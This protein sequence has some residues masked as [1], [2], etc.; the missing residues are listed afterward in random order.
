MRANP[1]AP[2]I[3][4][5]RLFDTCVTFGRVVRKGTPVSVTADNILALMDKHD[6]AEALV[7]H[8]EAR[9]NTPRELGNRR[10]LREIDGLP[11]VHPV[12][13]LTPPQPPDAG[14]ARAVVDEMLGSGVKAAR[15][16]MS[17]APP[18]PWLWRDLLEALEARRVPCLLDFGVGGFRGSAGSTMGAPDAFD[19]HHLRETALAHPELPMI[20]SHVCCGVGLPQAVFSLF[21]EC[22]NVHL[23]VLGIITY[24]RDVATGLGPE[25]VFFASGMPFGDPATYVSNV[26]YARR[27]TPEDKKRICGDNMRRL[28]GDVR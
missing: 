17:V 1:Q 15:L 9:L 10:L 7:H 27:L 18:L 11:R 2:P 12:W 6:I 26:Q 4:E 28:L 24:W 19:A 20:L 8:N 25:R 22:P 23:D 3:D 13:V 21:W 16:L 5:L 14:A